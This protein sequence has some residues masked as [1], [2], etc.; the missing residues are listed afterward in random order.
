MKNV[1]FVQT[2]ILG[3]HKNNMKDQHDFMEIHR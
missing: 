2:N 3:Y 1:D